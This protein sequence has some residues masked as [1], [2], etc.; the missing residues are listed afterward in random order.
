MI[1]FLPMLIL[2]V[3]LVLALVDL[4]ATRSASHDDVDHEP[5]KARYLG[6]RAEL[7]RGDES[8]P[9]VG[10]RMSRFDV[11]ANVS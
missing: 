5:P 2:G 10:Q 7:R 8:S 4:M 1:A 3:P 11:P 9:V 6:T